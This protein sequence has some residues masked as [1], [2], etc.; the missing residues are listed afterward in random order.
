MDYL[1]FGLFRDELGLEPQRAWAVRAP[2]AAAAGH[3]PEAMLRQGSPREIRISKSSGLG[4]VRAKRECHVALTVFAVGESFSSVLGNADGK[5]VSA[6]TAK[7]HY[8]RSVIAF[9]V[10]L[11]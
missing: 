5:T 10:P 4:E 1:S 7:S 6:T 2:P 3:T 9:S 8:I 11:G